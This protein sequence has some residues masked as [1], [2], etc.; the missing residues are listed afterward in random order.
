MKV[1][2]QSKM[3]YREH[4]LKDYKGFAFTWKTRALFKST[5]KFCTTI[6]GLSSKTETKMLRPK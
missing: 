1:E 2:N 5:S 3:E 6:L 4:V